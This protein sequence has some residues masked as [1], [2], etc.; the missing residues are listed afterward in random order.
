MYFIQEPPIE[1]WHTSNSHPCRAQG[2]AH[3]LP[4]KVVYKHM[5][6]E[7]GNNRFKF[8]WRAGAG[9]QPFPISLSM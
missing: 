7:I 8:Y 5:E 3:A 4:D 6:G 1:Q 9:I 2:F